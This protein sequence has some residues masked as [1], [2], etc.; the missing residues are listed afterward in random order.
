MS[1]PL[2]DGTLSEEHWYEHTIRD[3]V[4][5]CNEYGLDAVIRDIMKRWADSK[6]M[7]EGL[8]KPNE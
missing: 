4:T 7:H 1:M 3:V 2:E 6:P 5:L 8:G